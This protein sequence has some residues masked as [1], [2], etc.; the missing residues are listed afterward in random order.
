M[1][2]GGCQTAVS[3]VVNIAAVVLRLP[4]SVVNDVFDCSSGALSS[5]DRG[6]HCH[7]LVIS[8]MTRSFQAAASTTKLAAAA[9]AATHTARLQD[10]NPGPPCLQ[11]RYYHY[12]TTYLVVVCF[13]N[14]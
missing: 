4:F 11:Y 10:P 3:A 5:S 12:A 13:S 8:P 2:D 1:T 7:G 14:K 9:L 6:R